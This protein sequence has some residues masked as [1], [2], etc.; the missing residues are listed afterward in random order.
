MKY[1]ITESQYQ[2]IK[3]S[4]EKNK[5]FLIKTMGVDLTDNIQ[6][7]NS[8]YDVPTEFDEGISPDLVRRML[9]NWGPMYLFNLNGKDYLYQDRGEYEWFIDT[10]GFEFVDNEIIEKLGVDVLGMDF[11]D[12][13][14]VFYTEDQSINESTEKDYTSLIDKFISEYDFP[15]YFKGYNIGRDDDAYKVTFVVGK[16]Q[17]KRYQEVFKVIEP[18]FDDINSFIPINVWPKV[19]YK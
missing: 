2:S 19:E 10:E 18:L 17:M 3:E 14:K 12:I 16:E 5:K 7:V 13:I 1:I 11:S 15:D 9:N 4:L 6:M 8:R